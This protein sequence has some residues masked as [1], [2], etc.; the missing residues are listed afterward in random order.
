MPRPIDRRCAD[1]RWCEIVPTGAECRA[2]APTVVGWP[3]VDLLKG[4]C[5]EFSPLKPSVPASES[6]EIDSH[7]AAKQVQAGRDGMMT[8]PMPGGGRG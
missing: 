3:M 7:V 6:V 1:C 8:A 5:G 2:N 4:W